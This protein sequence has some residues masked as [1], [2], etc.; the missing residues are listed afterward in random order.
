MP[1]PG[2]KLLL[3]LLDQAFASKAWHG[4]V[5]LGSIRGVK[6]KAATFRP[7]GK[8]NSIR[9]LV[10]HCAYWKYAARRWVR[11]AA[12]D[13][14]GPAFARSP[15]KFPVRSERVTEKMWRADIRMLKR[16]HALIV[17]AVRRFPDRLLD[18]RK[19]DSPVTFAELIA[20]VAQHDLYH[21]GQI[22]LLKRL[23]G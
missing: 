13:Q 16:E 19:G 8:R 15:A 23:A 22:G 21:C 4:P 7:L 11:M 18:S 14:P 6:L 12:G 20:G 5:L 3:Q 9:D 2:I 1:A 10:Y 17:A